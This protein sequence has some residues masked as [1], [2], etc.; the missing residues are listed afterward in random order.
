MDRIMGER[1]F[2][3]S[4]F[5]ALFGVTALA[6]VTL[7]PNPSRVIGHAEFT[8]AT[9]NPNLVEGRELYAP[10]GIVVDT[11]AHPPVLYVSDTGNNRVMVWKNAAGFPN[12]ASAD[13]VIGQ[14]D[15]YTTFPQ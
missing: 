8:L 2:S 12:G 6:Q 14:K 5:A 9:A 15:L 1:L 13:L 11:S 10:Q 4:L 3:V 7:N